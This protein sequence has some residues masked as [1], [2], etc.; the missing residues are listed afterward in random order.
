[1]SVLFSVLVLHWVTATDSTRN[2]SGSVHAALGERSEGSQLGK[3]NHSSVAWCASRS[4]NQ[5][6]QGVVTT[7]C[8]ANAKDIRSNIELDKIRVQTEQTREV[9]VDGRSDNS[10]EPHQAFPG[11]SSSTDNIV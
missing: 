9:E 3:A 4:E 5:R 10:G 6:A 11:Q 7:E 1:M 2:P 8:V